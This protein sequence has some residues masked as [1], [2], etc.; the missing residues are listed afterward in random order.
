MEYLPTGAFAIFVALCAVVFWVCSADFHRLCDRVEKLESLAIQCSACTHYSFGR[1]DES[2]ETP[3]GM[4]L[5]MCGATGMRCSI[6][7]LRG[8]KC[9]PE[10]KLFEIARSAVQSEPRLSGA[11]S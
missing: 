9:G 6:S 4:V 10:A 1:V 11:D 7:R 2:R 8:Q 5:E 3:R